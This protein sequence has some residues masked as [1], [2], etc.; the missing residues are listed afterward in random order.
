MFS[1]I[2]INFL[3]GLIGG[4]FLE[5]IYRSI[6]AQKIIIPKFIDCQIYGL[7]GAFLVLIYFFNIS[8]LYE[9]ILIFI[10]PTLVEFLTGYF[11]LK[12]NRVYLWDYS[13]E[14]FNFKKLI[15]LKFSLIWFVITATYYYLFLQT[16]V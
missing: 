9:L 1:L 10:F 15:C 2:I 11:Y 12:I 8:L 4:F 6:K 7:T 14:K 5:L 16:I 3:I 13:R